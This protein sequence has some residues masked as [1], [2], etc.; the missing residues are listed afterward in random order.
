MLGIFSLALA[1]EAGLVKKFKGDSH[2]LRDGKE[3]SIDV[4]TKIFDADTIITKKNS[5]VGLIFK[6]NTRIAVGANSEFKIEEYLF[7][8]GEKKITFRTNLIKGSLACVTGLVSK[9]NPRAFELKAKSATIG[10]R[11]T[12]FIVSAD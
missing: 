6:D 10:I 5:S 1:N 4:G 11:G 2:I 7:D 9:T 8:L 12:Y 3:L